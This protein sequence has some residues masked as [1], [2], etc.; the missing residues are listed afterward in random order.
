MKKTIINTFIILLLFRLLIS[1]LDYYG[2]NS[3]ELHNELLKYFTEA[4]IVKGESYSR[5]GFAI[6]ITRSIIFAFMILV[7]SFTSLSKKLEIV[8]TK[9]A[10]NKFFLSSLFFIAVFYF[11]ITAI[12]LPFNFYFSYFNEHRFGFSNMTM[13]LWFWTRFKSFALTLLFISLTGSLALLVIKKF[14]FYSVFIAPAGGLIIGLIM[15]IVYPLAILPMFYEIKGIENPGLEKRIIEIAHKSG[16]SVDKIYVIE[17]SR[18]S[19]HTNAFFV[20]FGNNKRIYLYDTLIQNNSESE[21]ISILT[22]E[23]GHWAYNHNLK[24][25]FFGFI[26][27]LCAFLAGYY[28]L[29]KLL[30]E[31]EF[32]CIEM[33]SP[34]LIPV[35]LLLFIIF[36]TLTNP[37][38]MAVSRKMEREADYYAL[39][40]T[41]D[42]DAFISSEIK[43]A[44]D[45]SSRLNR[46]PVPAFFRNSHPMTIERIKMAERF[47]DSKQ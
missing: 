16:I 20:G 14:K 29:K 31:S 34:S 42:P 25:A 37:L 22:H 44:R 5:S 13:G 6:A 15:I 32:D 8:C 38:E 28:C 11:F 27:S 39:R 12:S 30:E 40:I 7:L 47:R 41:E 24:G 36:S 45:N 23:I 21:I 3:I 43:I 35:Y 18:Y 2:N 9:L 4:D 26:L 19:K 1:F 10:K 46:H 17:E 33:H